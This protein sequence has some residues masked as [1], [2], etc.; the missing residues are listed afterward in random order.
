MNPP[1]EIIDYI[2]LAAV[3]VVILAVFYTPSD[4]IP[5]TTSPMFKRG[6]IVM[7]LGLLGIWLMDNKVERYSFW[8]FAL[9]VAIYGGTPLI[10]FFGDRKGDKAWQA[11]NE[12]KKEAKK[13]ESER[14]AR[15]AEQNAAEKE[16]RADHRRKLLEDEEALPSADAE[17]YRS[18]N[19]TDITEAAKALAK[20][21][22]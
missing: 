12:A 5:F 3:V 8:Y 17:T 19:P 20:K 16:K 9:D 7:P 11:T 15:H 13:Q 22:Q 2:F 10:L 18:A 1:P 4:E 21:L 6:I 14:L